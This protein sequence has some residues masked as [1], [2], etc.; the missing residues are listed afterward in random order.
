MATP[1]ENLQRFQEIANRGLQD[2]LDPE[3]RKRFDEALRR[4]LVQ[5]QEQPA[6]FQGQPRSIQELQGLGV[7]RV[8]GG[9]A[10][11]ELEQAISE[12][13]RFTNQLIQTG[14]FSPLFKDL[15]VETVNSILRKLPEKTKIQE[16]FTGA[17]RAGQTPT[18]P[19]N[20]ATIRRL[21]NLER[22]RFDSPSLA[23]EIENLPGFE[24]FS[25][26]AGKL[27]DDLIQGGGRLIGLL[28][29]DDVRDSP[30]YQALASIR[31]EAKAGEVAAQTALFAVPAARVSQIPTTG[32]ALAAPRLAAGSALGAV[33]SGLP[34]LG[35][36][37]TPEQAAKTALVGA[38]L[39]LGS[40]L[41]FNQGRLTPKQREIRAAL[42][43]NPR[44]PKLFDI[45]IRGG[46]PRK[47][48]AL[49]EAARQFGDA[50]PEFVAVAKE[51]AKRDK[52]KLREMLSIVNRGRTDPLFR[53]NNRVGQV[54]GQSLTDR[55]KAVK[56]LNRR[57]GTQLDMV[58]RTLKDKPVDISG[59][60]SRY[61][62]GLESLRVN[63]NPETGAV[64]FAGSALEGKGLGPIRDLVKRLSSSVSS[65]DIDAFD[66][67]FMK[68]LIDQQVT[69]GKA[70]QGL[71]GSVENI[72]KGLRRDIDGVLDD[73]FPRYDR[74]N[75]RYA[76][77]IN[78]LNDMQKAAGASIDLTSDRALG[79]SARRLTSNA[80]SRVPF[81]D[82]IRNLQE[83]AQNQG[84]T[85]KDDISTQLF[86]T[87]QLES[88]FG[89]PAETALRGEVTKG[90]RDIA[91]K[92]ASTVLL[93]QGGRVLERVRGIDDESTI[94]AILRILE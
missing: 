69:F 55:V 31:P 61:R 19:N 73:A 11:L 20:I 77:T 13:S 9:Q 64:N 92:R 29:E 18:D 66:A 76:E 47:V 89:S 36:G 93:E 54:I 82:A 33:E 35:R 49:R 39:Q 34:A 3:R 51:A 71:S 27:T 30:E 90:I 43:A 2:Q 25:I 17:E 79:Q 22:L 41:I 1:Q 57:A 48:K 40:G 56:G 26:G 59:A 70:G 32:A 88:R 68:R 74:V 94:N 46:K 63:F 4:G 6:S 52:N 44:D 53:Q 28:D 8:S 16:G 81:E 23:E 45:A 10:G 65:T 91:E 60:V 83:V 12:S 50:G 87:N 21:S 84:V 24:V 42:Q 78:A 80:Q 7:G 85:F 58:A 14:Q 15:P 67:H 38:G 75:T 62:E 5:Q 72:I 86:F 37:E